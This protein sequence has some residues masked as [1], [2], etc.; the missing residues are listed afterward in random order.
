MNDPFSEVPR[1]EGGLFTDA[2]PRLTTTCCSWTVPAV[3]NAK[4][5]GSDV[6]YSPQEHWDK[7]LMLTIRG[8]EAGDRGKQGPEQMVQIMQRAPE[9][10]ILTHGRKLCRIKSRSA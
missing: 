3:Y 2:L 6:G 7:T 5:G 8:Q 10:F 1:R 9:N 4:M